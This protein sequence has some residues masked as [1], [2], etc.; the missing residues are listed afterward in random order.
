MPAPELKTFFQTFTADQFG[1]VELTGILDIKEFRTVNF[2]IVNW[3]NAHSQ[4]SRSPLLWGR[5]VDRRSH[6][7]SISSLWELMGSSEHTP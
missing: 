4:I 2:Q 1:H 6:S 5:S 7:R 3:P